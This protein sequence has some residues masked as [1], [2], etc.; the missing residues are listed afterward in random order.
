MGEIT[1]VMN[2]IPKD[3]ESDRISMTIQKFS[4]TAD[5]SREFSCNLLRRF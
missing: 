5:H 2:V 3:R 4:G 1:D